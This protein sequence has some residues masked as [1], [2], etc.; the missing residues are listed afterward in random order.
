MS[1]RIFVQ[2]RP[3][4]VQEPV[5]P[6]NISASRFHE[7][8]LPIPSTWKREIVFPE[9]RLH[10][11]DRRAPSQRLNCKLRFR[12]SRTHRLLDGVESFKNL[13]VNSPQR[14]S[15]CHRTMNGWRSRGDGV[16]RLWKLIG[17]GQFKRVGPAAQQLQRRQSLR[18]DGHG[19]A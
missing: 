5:P 14:R 9:S 13:F 11:N 1:D 6:G 10:D 4:R 7:P 19:G 2:F 12:R 17:C 8:P 3:S 16:S 15:L 18:P